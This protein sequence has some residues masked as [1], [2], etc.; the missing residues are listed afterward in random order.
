MRHVQIL[1]KII[2]L[3]K[4]RKIKYGFRFLD[5]RRMSSILLRTI[6]GILLLLP[7]ALETNES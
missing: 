4:K 7:I 3:K 1:L 6:S 5:L 2:M